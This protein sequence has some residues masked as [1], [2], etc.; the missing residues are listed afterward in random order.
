MPDPGIASL[1][2]SVLF[3]LLSLFPPLCPLPSLPFLL[4]PWGP[5]PLPLNC[6]RGLGEDC[7]IHHCVRAGGRQAHFAA[8]SI[9]RWKFHGINFLYFNG[10]ICEIFSFNVCQ[11]SL[12][13]LYVPV[14]DAFWMI[15][16]WLVGWQEWHRIGPV[17][18]LLQFQNFSSDDTIWP[19]TSPEE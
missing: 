14:G 8:F 19:G 16:Y 2:P 15:H 4:P 5:L 12:A 17:K 9:L 7:K 6:L 10:Q 13:N 18:N 3:P 1:P 11:S